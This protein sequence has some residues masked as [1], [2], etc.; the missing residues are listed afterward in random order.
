MKKLVVLLFISSFSIGFTQNILDTSAFAHKLDSIWHIESKLSLNYFEGNRSLFVGATDIVAGHRLGESSA[1]WFIGGF[2]TV[3]SEGT[4][5][6]SSTYG[7]LRYNKSI[8]SRLTLNTYI[9]FQSNNV[10][11]LQARYLIGTN[12][13]FDAKKTEDFLSIGVF[14][15]REEFSLD[16]STMIFRGNVMGSLQL[17]DRQLKSALVLY[18]QPSLESMKDFRVLVNLNSKVPVSNKMTI[19]LDVATR[20]DNLPNTDLKSFDLNSLFTL[21]YKI[22]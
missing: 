11:D 2:N 9:Q 8:S 10:L 3:S 6:R 5:I 14:Y 1:L 20:F 7:H 15:E 16:P 21:S 17:A 19:G 18:Y 4:S 12:A 13:T 22:K